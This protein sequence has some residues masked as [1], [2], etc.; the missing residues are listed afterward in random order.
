[1][2]IGRVRQSADRTEA[3]PG[4]AGG[5]GPQR[6]PVPSVAAAPRPARFHRVEL[7]AS[8]GC[9]RCYCVRGSPWMKLTIH[10]TVMDA[11]RTCGKSDIMQDTEK[12]STRQ[13]QPLSAPRSKTP[14]LVLLS[15]GEISFPRGQTQPGNFYTKTHFTC[16]LSR[17]FDCCHPGFE[18][19]ASSFFEAC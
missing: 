15:C 1:L 4:N 12:F 16:Q 9:R 14:D 17:Q 7:L 5:A 18:H 3:A 11:S 10:P 13:C 2:K 19:G 8:A 6:V